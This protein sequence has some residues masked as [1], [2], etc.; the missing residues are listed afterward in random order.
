MFDALKL[1][2]FFQGYTS[3]RYYSSWSRWGTICPHANVHTATYTQYTWWHSGNSK[4]CC[5]V[6]QKLVVQFVAYI[7]SSS[8]L[9]ASQLEKRKPSLLFSSPEEQN[10]GPFGDA[11]TSATT[12]ATCSDLKLKW[13]HFTSP[14]QRKLFNSFSLLPY[15]NA[16]Q[17]CG[18]FWNKDIHC[19]ADT[20]CGPDVS[21]VY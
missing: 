15:Y 8:N 12:A 19:N 5:T 17:P 21:Y 6:Y 11:T 10:T 3:I 20:A 4:Q 7:S 9:A 2:V 14:M 18:Q 16:T 1:C 13:L